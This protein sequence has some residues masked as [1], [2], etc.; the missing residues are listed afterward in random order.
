MR[1]RAAA[2]DL[3]T[4]CGNAAGGS[5]TGM[6]IQSVLRFDVRTGL[7]QEGQV[8]YYEGHVDFGSGL[9]GRCAG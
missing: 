2:I 9:V 8:R 4:G 5:R 6:K 1:F 3:Q 7:D